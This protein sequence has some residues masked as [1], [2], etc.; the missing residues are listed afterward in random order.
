MKKTVEITCCDRCGTEIAPDALESC[1]GFDLCRSCADELQL[2]IRA[3]VEELKTPETEAVSESADDSSAEPEAAPETPARREA[4]R[5]EYSGF[6]HIKCSG[7]GAIKTFCTKKPMSTYRCYDCGTDTVLTNMTAV[8]AD[9]E[10]GKRSRYM[11]NIDEWGFD[12]ACVDCGS[13]M[14]V[15]YRP[16]VNQ[17]RTCGKSFVKSRKRKK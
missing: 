16:G 2:R 9:C 15:E 7:C 1:E 14:A 10:C 11:T 17:Y 6:L 12:L 5:E 13:P 4:E 3:F 8:Y